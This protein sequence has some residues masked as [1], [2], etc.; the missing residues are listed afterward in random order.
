MREAGFAGDARA[1]SRGQALQRLFQSWEVVLERLPI[2]AYVCDA[3]GSIVRYNRRVTGLWSGAPTGKSL[4][5][6]PRLA[7]CHSLVSEVLTSGE[8]VKDRDVAFEHSDGQRTNLLADAQ[9]IS[10]DDG[11][12]IGVLVC[13][14]DVTELRQAREMLRA[15][16]NWSRRI[17]ESSPV[18]I[19]QTDA[20]GVVQAF[21]SAAATLWGREPKIGEDRWCGSFKL[22]WPDG[23]PMPLDACPMAQSIRG[24]KQISGAEAIFERPDG[25][26]GAF[27]AYPTPLLGAD[28]ELV[29]AINLLVDITERKRAEDLQ[30]TLLDELNHRVKN[31]LATVQSLAAHS[32]RDVGDP[33]C[34]RQAFEARL[35]A[36]SG[37]HNQ[38]ADRRWEAADMLDVVAGILGP[39]GGEAVFWEGPSIQLPTRVSVALAMVL[40]ELATNAGKYGA[41]SMPEGRLLVIGRERPKACRWNGARPV[42]RR[43][44]SLS[45]KDL[46]SDSSAARS[47]GNSPG[48]SL[49]TS[50]KQACAAGSSR[51]FRLR[52]EAS[53]R[54]EAFADG[55]SDHSRAARNHTP[56]IKP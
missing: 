54:P 43:R 3:G 38:L 23:T 5:D 28:G 36:L 32:F 10:D 33:V 55:R 8:A 40:H 27:L 46:G 48:R 16:Q 17:L 49:S 35:M 53:P 52:L 37:A 13:I 50:P 21:N 15:R 2:A 25:S 7:P 29:G 47:S 18:A 42:V 19:Y 9:P 31:T 41:L 56:V 4:A 45:T 30:K 11:A 1:P 26:R 39:Y 14:Q 34:M 44:P 51:R 22:Q 12:L 24:R 6:N 20:E